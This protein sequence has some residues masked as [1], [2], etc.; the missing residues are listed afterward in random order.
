[1]KTADAPRVAATIPRPAQVRVPEPRPP[2]EVDTGPVV[3]GVDGSAASVAALVWALR[4]AAADNRLVMVVTAWPLRSRVFVHEVPGHFNDAR[5]EAGQA[6]ARA[7]AHALSLVDPA[8]PVECLLVNAPVLDAVVAAAGRDVLVVL[9]TDR[10]EPAEEPA[11]R[12]PALT[13][14]A[15]DLADGPV[16]LVSATGT[17]IGEG[18]T[19]WASCSGRS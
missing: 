14:R 13:A 8:P 18:P 3:V 17:P 9:G 12:G 11:G 1:M 6:Q 10:T 7:V 16:L 4:H 5:A 15:Q 2:A 19:W